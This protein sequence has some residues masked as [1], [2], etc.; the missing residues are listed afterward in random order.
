MSVPG[1]AEGNQPR[2]A[3]SVTPARRAL[4][5]RALKEIG[6]IAV[7]IVLA[8]VITAIVITHPTLTTPVMVDVG[9]TALLV[10]LY[11][12]WRSRRRH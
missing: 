3:T 1:D 9:V 6:V 8:T 10:T 4:R 11:N 2:A 7:A 5:S 12:T